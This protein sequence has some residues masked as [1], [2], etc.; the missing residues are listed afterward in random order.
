MLAPECAIGRKLAG[1]DEKAPRYVI[2]DVRRRWSEWDLGPTPSKLTTV[3]LAGG[4]SPLNKV[5]LLAFSDDQREVG[6]AVKLPRVDE[7]ERALEH[8]SSALRAIS[9]TAVPRHVEIPR[10]VASGRFADLLVVAETPVFGTPV[11]DLLDTRS[12]REIAFNLSDVLARWIPEQGLTDPMGYWDR[13]VEP[14]FERFTTRCHTVIEDWFVL[15]LRQSMHALPPLPLVPEHRDCSPWNVLVTSA[16]GFA[17]LDWE[18]AEPSGLPGL[19]LIY[20][21]ANAAF[22]L[23]GTLGSGEELS[24][25]RHL[26]S[27]HSPLAST[28]HRT[29]AR[30]CQQTRIDPTVV[31]TLR[32]F[33]W[34]VHAPGE[35]DR[36]AA[37][38]PRLDAAQSAH[39]SVLLSLWREEVD[40]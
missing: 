38:D 39:R 34:M 24:T 28:F 36:I 40:R 8:E 15:A 13:V 4:Q 29:M 26:L 14:V 11:L 21:L 17:L 9:R 20:F 12:F 7:A 32:A 3:M 23:D 27:N 1:G 31:Q 10:V 33:T 6:L 22:Y 37:L 30:Y 19:D 25:Y 5:V 16:G 2:E 35:C 18:S